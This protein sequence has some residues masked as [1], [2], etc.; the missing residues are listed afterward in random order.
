MKAI[1][2]FRVFPP[3]SAE[4]MFSAA[5]YMTDKRVFSAKDEKAVPRL[6]AGQVEKV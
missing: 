6:S 1:S 2:V 4:V 3:C 5:L